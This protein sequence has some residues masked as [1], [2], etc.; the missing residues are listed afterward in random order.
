MTPEDFPRLFATAFGAQD[1]AA[2]AGF[3]AED[4]QVVTLTGAVAED[5][6]GA[7]A[8]FAAEF[9]GIFAAARLV[10]GRQRLRMLGPGGAVLHQR[11][12]VTGARDAGGR[13]MPRFGALLTAV[14]LAR[15]GGWRAVSLSFS[16]LTQ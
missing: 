12:V 7:E 3:L 15:E 10:T 13:E 11:F 16:A 14:L 9:A 5:A 4:A 2:L 8:A 6:A 1:G